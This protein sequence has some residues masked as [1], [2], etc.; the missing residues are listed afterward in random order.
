LKRFL[1][2]GIVFPRAC[3]LLALEHDEHVRTARVLLILHHERS[4][5]ARA[6]LFSPPYLIL[7]PRQVAFASRPQPSR[8]QLRPHRVIPSADREV[9]THDARSAAAQR[10]VDR[11][12]TARLQPSST[13]RSL[14]SAPRRWDVSHYEFRSCERCETILDGLDDV[15]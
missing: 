10:A 8:D 7:E 4:D 6:G 12:L 5:E 13:A 15:P 3:P 14:Y 2:S 1:P 9:R 11:Q